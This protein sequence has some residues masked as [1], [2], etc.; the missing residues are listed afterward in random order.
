M[1]WDALGALGEIVG[2]TAVVLT[3]FYLARQV[4]EASDEA[5]QNQVELR[6]TRYDQLN[7][8]LTL[9]ANDWATNS[10]LSDIMLRGFTAVSSLNPDEVFR[11]YANL[12]RFFRGLEALFVYSAEGGIHE[13]GAQGWR[14]A[15]T[16]FV[17]YPGVR[18]YWED[19]H[20]WYSEGFQSEVDGL[21]SSSTSVI[22]Q[23]YRERGVDARLTDS[24][25]TA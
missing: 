18:A 21:L 22:A 8:E 17:T 1:N 13:W 20:H 25:G 2:A 7:R 10:E 19:R 14:V 15:L 12:Q 3:L 11:F 4:R 23:A 24:T 5:R 6:R 9:T 16:D